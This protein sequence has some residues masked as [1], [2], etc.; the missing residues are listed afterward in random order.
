VELTRCKFVGE[1][2]DRIHGKSVGALYKAQ[3]L[4]ARQQRSEGRLS[5]AP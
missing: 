5:A 1:L 4:K 2:V 3:P